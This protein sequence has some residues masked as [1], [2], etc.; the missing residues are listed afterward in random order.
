MKKHQ[1]GMRFIQK[2]HKIWF[3][4]AKTSCKVYGVEK[5]GDPN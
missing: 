2:L 1:L 3:K 4:T 5:V